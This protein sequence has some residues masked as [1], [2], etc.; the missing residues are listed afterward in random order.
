MSPG[1]ESSVLLYPLVPEWTSLG[2]C[3]HCSGHKDGV[4]LSLPSWSCDSVGKVQENQVGSDV[5]T[6]GKQG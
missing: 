5:S 3:C 4:G 2:G 1:I 6:Q